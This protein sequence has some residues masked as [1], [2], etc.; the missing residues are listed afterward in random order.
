VTLVLDSDDSIA[1]SALIIGAPIFSAIIVAAIHCHILSGYTTSK[2]TNSENIALFRYL[3]IFS[4]LSAI[5]GNIVQ[6]YGIENDSISLT[7]S[8]NCFFLYMRFAC[9]WEFLTV[10]FSPLLPLDFG[11]IP[12][13]FC[14]SRNSTSSICDMFYSCLFDRSRKRSFD[15]IASDRTNIWTF[16]RI[17][18]WKVDNHKIRIQF[19]VYYKK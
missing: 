5:V 4:C 11:K 15:A 8:D 7:V 6:V 12:H 3:L 2:Q 17:F 19:R 13:G 18:S 14:R 9:Y 16:D 10:C 1:Y